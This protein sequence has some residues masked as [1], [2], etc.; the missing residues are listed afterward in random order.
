[1]EPYNRN[2]KLSV[3]NCTIFSLHP[4]I[5]VLSAVFGVQFPVFLLQH[6]GGRVL[7]RFTKK[8]DG[9]V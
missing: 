1:M 4:G 7:P 9:T 5:L 3:V 8:W 6:C 2:F